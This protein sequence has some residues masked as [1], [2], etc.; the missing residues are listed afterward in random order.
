VTSPALAVCQELESSQQRA[1]EF[2]K[3]LAAKIQLLGKESM[4]TSGKSIFL[5]PFASALLTSLF[6][7]N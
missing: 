4:M 1:A 5:I 3:E 6:T 7:E 2:E